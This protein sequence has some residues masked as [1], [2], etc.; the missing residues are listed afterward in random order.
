M[1]QSQ[2]SVA[3]SH[4]IAFHASGFL[5]KVEGSWTEPALAQ[6]RH[7]LRLRR[8]SPAADELL[9]LLTQAKENYCAGK[10]RLYLCAAQ[11]CCGQSSFD[12]SA[13]ALESLSR[14]LG[15]PIA[16][17]GCQGPCKQA[18]VLS[19]RIGERQQTFAQVNSEKDWRAVFAFVK[20]AVQTGSLLIDPGKAEEFL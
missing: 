1:K 4:E 5:V 16:K 18:P 9:N 17:T 10:N 12:T 8:L 19:L 20:A 2:K 14:E 15:L 11:P 13:D 6:F 3:T 7:F